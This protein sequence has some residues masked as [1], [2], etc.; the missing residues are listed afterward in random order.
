MINSALESCIA[1][2][3]VL[4]TF[5]SSKSS[6]A[7]WAVT[8]TDV[9]GSSYPAARTL[10]VY[11]P[12]SILFGGKLYWPWALL[13]TQVVI[14]EPTFFAPTRRSIGRYT[15]AESFGLDE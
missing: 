2:F 3:E 15:S 1:R 13:T 12:V 10:T 14:V 11:L 7:G 8:S 6:W 4:V 9:L 5:L